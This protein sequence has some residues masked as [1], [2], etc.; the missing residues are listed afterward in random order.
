MDATYISVCKSISDVLN[1]SIV[2]NELQD[3]SD[4]N[5]GYIL[6]GLAETIDNYVVVRTIVNKKHGRLKITTNYMR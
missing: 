1:N 2:M 6:L 3:R 5:G 4:N